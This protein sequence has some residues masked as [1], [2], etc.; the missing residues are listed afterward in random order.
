MRDYVYK[1]STCNRY[2]PEQTREPFVP[3]DVPER[4]WAKVGMYLFQVDKAD[5]VIV[6]DYYSNFFE[7]PC[8]LWPFP[9]CKS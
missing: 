5:C 1:C 8:T 3:D 9:F 4:S 7:G 2:R 6:V